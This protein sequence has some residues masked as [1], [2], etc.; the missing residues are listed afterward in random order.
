MKTEI[1]ATRKINGEVY[2]FYLNT[3]EYPGETGCCGIEIQPYIS[4]K[5]PEN[6]FGYPDTVLFNYGKAYTLERYLAPYIKRQLTK[7][8]KRI[9]SRLPYTIINLA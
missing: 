3:P 8:A 2:T 5:T 1:V 4:I 7:T 9:A 6:C